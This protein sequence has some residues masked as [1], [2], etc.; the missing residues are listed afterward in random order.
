[1]VCFSFD[2]VFFLSF[3]ICVYTSHKLSGGKEHSMDLPCMRL[4]IC[5]KCSQEKNQKT[6]LQ[7]AKVIL[8][9]WQNRADS[10]VGTA[11]QKP[12]LPNPDRH[13]H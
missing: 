11:N 2:D 12:T 6:H 1:M 10:S 7:E 8:A 9:T 5:G 4:P 13:Q 3:S